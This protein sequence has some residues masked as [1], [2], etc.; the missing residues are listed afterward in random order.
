ME[1]YGDGGKPLKPNP[2]RCRHTGGGFLLTR[3]EMMKLNYA[4]QMKHPEWQKKRLE[5][6]EYYGF[7]CQNCGSK[8]EELHVHHPFYKRGAMIWQYDVDDLMCLCHKCHKEEH[9]LDE[10]IKKAVA[11]LCGPSFKHQALGYLE[12]LNG[13]TPLYPTSYKYCLGVADFVSYN[14][15][16]LNKRNHLNDSVCNFVCENKGKDGLFFLENLG[17]TD[18]P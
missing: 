16:P 17:V 1:K 7:E 9:E 10:R 6:L 5:A 8:D 2:Q 11:I 3:E 14:E 18:A 4:Q 13:D 15:L 12:S